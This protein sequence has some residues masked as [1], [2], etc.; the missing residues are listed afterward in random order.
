MPVVAW[1]AVM[2]QSYSISIE[3]LNS[4]GLKWSLSFFRVSHLVLALGQW[5][6]IEAY[7][8]RPLDLPYH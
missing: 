5:S 6:A 2:D 8:I 3:G 1:S 4:V 7:Q